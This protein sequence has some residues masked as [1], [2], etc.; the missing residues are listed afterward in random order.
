MVRRRRFPGLVPGKRVYGPL[1]LPDV[2]PPCSNLAG[3]LVPAIFFWNPIAIIRRLLESG[4]CQVEN[5]SDQASHEGPVDADVLQ[6][7]AE[8][9][10]EA[11]C[12]AARIPLPNDLDDEAPQGAPPR[13]YL[14]RH[15]FYRAVDPGA[16][17]RVALQVLADRV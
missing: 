1:R 16:H 11:L 12:Q 3:T 14:C 6:V 8:R 4:H 13:Y 7:P 2:K 17:R 10:L 9:R 5:A 15:R